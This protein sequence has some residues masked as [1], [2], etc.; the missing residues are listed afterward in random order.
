LSKGLAFMHFACFFDF[1]Q[2]LAKRFAWNILATL[3]WCHQMN[4]NHSHDYQQTF[5]IYIL[6]NIVSTET[7]VQILFCTLV[8]QFMFGLVAPSQK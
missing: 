8:F 4:D 3:W 7:L 6:Y 2:P 5:I 1:H